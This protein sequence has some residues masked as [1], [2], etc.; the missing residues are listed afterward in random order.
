MPRT[1]SATGMSARMKTATLAARL[2]RPD[3][4]AAAAGGTEGLV[5]LPE[6]HPGVHRADQLFV[7]V[8]HQRLRR[9]E[10]A[11]DAAFG[12]LA[13]ARMIDVR[14]HVRVETVL[15]GIGVVPR[16]VR[17]LVDEADVDDRLDVLEAV[18]PGDDETDWG[19]VLVEQGLAVQPDGEQRERVHGFVPAKP[20]RVTPVQTAVGETGHFRR[21]QDRLHLDEGRFRLRIRPLDHRGERDA[22]PRDHNPPPLD[23][24]EA[25]D[26]FLEIRGL[27]QIVDM[28]VAGLV[29]EAVDL[30]GPR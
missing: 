26:A 25:V 9:L 7:T 16:R 24:A 20:L 30:H 22:D 4:T 6:I 3:Y 5:V 11:R 10:V 8:E 2:T 1:R 14:V 13:P 18:L 21:A 27:D 17:H 28:V 23:A 12:R 19:A 29:A 15:A